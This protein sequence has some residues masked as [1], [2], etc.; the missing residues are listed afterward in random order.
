MADPK[1][2]IKY[3]RKEAGNRSV[4]ERVRDFGEV[5]QTL[6]T[7]DRIM[8]AARC[9]DCGVPFCHWHCPLGNLIPEF[10][11]AMYRGEWKE[12]FNILQ[13][14][15][16]FPE[17]TGRIC[18][19]LCEHSCV[20]GRYNESVTIRENE[21][22]IVERAF[23]EGYV[24]P[25]PPQKRTGKKV[26]VIGGGP[27][28]MVC[29]DDLNKAGHNVT[30]FE[31]NDSTGGLL[32]YGIPD[33]KLN[34]FIIDRRMSILEQ[35]G[36]EIRTNTMVG[37]DISVDDLLK[38]YDAIC[39]TIGALYP[40]DLPVEGRDIGGIHYAMDYLS[41]QNKLLK[42]IKIPDDEL[43]D[44]KNKK[45][46][47]IGG[48]DTGSDCVGTANRQGAK[49]VNQIE[50]MPEPP[51]IRTDDNPWPYY[52]KLLKTST[53][54]EEGC[55]RYWGIATERFIGENGNVKQV[56][57]IEVDWKIDESG[58]MNMI[59]QKD[60]KHLFDAD[61]VFLALGF[62]HPEHKGLLDKLGVEYDQRGNV[63]TDEHFH[64]SKPKVYAAGDAA[65]GASLVVRAMANAKETA[66][67]IDEE[68]KA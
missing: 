2:F 25:K 49:H 59:K 29:A 34:K 53:S 67:Q 45:V 10:Q 24:K 61:L 50:I 66:K 47:V 42:G 7:E 51:S 3:N 14:T 4:K 15:N 6:N 20:L 13:S 17:F 5:E 32:R 9:M 23:N 44:A 31:K 18:P 35:E 41:Q 58:K 12:A 11:D 19:A 40:R 54:H 36:L 68:L 38:K 16:N 62:L 46:L 28:G 43:I 55:E 26:A 65:C 30:L 37:E 21:V 33:F 48:G 57:T 8:Q 60:K 22:A 63:K 1:G 39:I 56:E 27:A 52:A 64:T